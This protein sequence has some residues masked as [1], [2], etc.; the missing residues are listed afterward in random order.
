MSLIVQRA[1]AE[2]LDL[3]PQYV[4]HVERCAEF[5]HAGRGPCQFS[6]SCRTQDLESL[7]TV[8]A[9]EL[10]WPEWEDRSHRLSLFVEACLDPS[11]TLDRSIFK[12]ELQCIRWHLFEKINPT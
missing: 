3:P 7:V 6:L 11:C 10:P 8:A 5:V 1:S 9:G 12:M 2:L 4:V